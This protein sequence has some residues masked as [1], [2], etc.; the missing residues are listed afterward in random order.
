MKTIIAVLALGEYWKGA[1]VLFHTLR[2][3]GRLPGSVD[4]VA[5]GAEHPCGST[6]AQ[7]QLADYSWVPVSMVHFPRVAGKFNA[8]SLGGYDR[9]I[10]MDADMMCLG[11]CS[12]LWSDR[13]GRLPFYASRDCASIVYY[14]KEIKRIDLDENLLFNAG[15]MV[16]HPSLLGPDWPGN[17]LKAICERKID[18][19]DG[20]DQGYL[21]AYFQKMR[22]ELEIGYLPQEYNGC[23]D[24]Y[25]PKL[26]DHAQRI[27]HFTGANV[28]PWHPTVGPGDRRYP[29]LQRWQREWRECAG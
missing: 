4:L 5:M 19:Y 9:V 25:I 7:P 8:F 23:T 22:P 3:Y 28:N 18:A 29:L 14:K 13:I 17:F 21:N 24:Q 26:P 10:L 11:D 2:K 27:V 15:T 12:Y 20:G 6:V 16:F 1:K